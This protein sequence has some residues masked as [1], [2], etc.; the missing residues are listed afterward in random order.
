ME[1]SEFTYE[2]PREVDNQDTQEI[3]RIRK[4]NKSF[5]LFDII[6]DLII[7]V[8]LIISSILFFVLSPYYYIGI[9]LLVISIVYIIFSIIYHK[10]KNIYDGE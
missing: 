6:K 4:A 7:E 1:K 5:H 8:F 2:E 3:I 9:I 10:R